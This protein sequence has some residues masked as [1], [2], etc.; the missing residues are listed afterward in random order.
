MAIDNPIVIDT[1]S[2]DGISDAMEEANIALETITLG[3]NAYLEKKRLYFSRFFFLSND[4]MLEILSETKDPLRVQP[5]LIKC[6]EGI[7]RLEFDDQLDIR[8]ILSSEKE[9]IPFGEPVSTTAARG[10]VEIWLRQVEESMIAAVKVQTS[11]SFL[12]YEQTDRLE[13]ILKWPQ[14]IVLCISQIFW[15]MSVELRLK[16]QH[17]NGLRSLTED[18]QTNINEV[19]DMIREPHLTNA[20]RI[21]LRSLIVIDVHAKDIVA[22][23]HEHRIISLDDF[24]WLAQLR[25]YWV[26][27][28]VQ[29]RIINAIIRFAYEY[30]GNSD[31]LVC[32]A[33]V[34]HIRVE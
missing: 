9:R 2:A 31:R 10:S 7:Y 23:L 12:D 26:D 17:L 11:H 21:T 34:Q 4:E 5:H 25:Y 8:A 1:A 27:G 24:Q 3:V 32:E 28:E 16:M 22:E 6:F 33:F 13:W 18:L 14:M 29:V 15:A 30:L 20:E 19:V